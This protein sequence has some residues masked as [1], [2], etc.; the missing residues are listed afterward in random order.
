LRNG[1]A[2]EEDWNMLRPPSYHSVFPLES[3]PMG[4]REAEG[5]EEVREEGGIDGGGWMG[6]G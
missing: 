5:R 2:V 4:S 3:T 6:E 1:T